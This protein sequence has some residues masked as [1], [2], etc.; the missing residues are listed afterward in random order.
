MNK[1]TESIQK[2]IA[3]AES[4]LKQ[5][6]LSRAQYEEKLIL[7]EAEGKRVVEKYKEK[8]QSLYDEILKEANK[9]AELVRLRAKVDAEREMEKANDEIKKQVI[10]MALLAASKAVEA[11]LDNKHQHMLIKQFISKVGM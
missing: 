1:R 11:Q 9:E 2:N 8:A 6:E 5:A 7:A 10:A 4:A 3:D